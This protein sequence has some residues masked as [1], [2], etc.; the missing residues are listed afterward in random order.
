MTRKDI[1]LTVGGILATMTLAYLFYELQQRD[2]A[3]K[4]AAS[5][6]AG[7]QAAAYGYGYDPTTQQ[8][9]QQ[10]AYVQS[11]P[12]I[13]IPDFSSQV[14]ASA[15]TAATGATG[16]SIDA[17]DESNLIT[18]I[19]AAYAGDNTTNPNLLPTLTLNDPIS[20]AV[21]NIP[22]SAQQ[23]AATPT[24]NGSGNLYWPLETPL[25][26]NQGANIAT[27]SAQQSNSNVS[28]HPVD[29]HPIITYGS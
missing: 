28:S 1:A 7:D 5:S 27:L 15:S 18:Q 19:I 13:S 9:Y 23:A 8:Y 17:T 25:T 16:T 3:A 10:A 22:I 29:T 24:S 2:A 12:Q 4:A 21:A 14:T 26:T 6:T 11:L 20:A